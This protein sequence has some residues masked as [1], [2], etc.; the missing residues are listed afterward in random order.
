LI[1][2]T[3]KIADKKWQHFNKKIEEL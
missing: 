2:I 3:S 1:C